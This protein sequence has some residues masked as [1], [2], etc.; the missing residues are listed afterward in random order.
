MGP[1]GLGFLT[2]KPITDRKRIVKLLLQ[3]PL[4]PK[5]LREQMAPVVLTSSML[6]Q[7]TTTPSLTQ[8]ELIDEIA[9]LHTVEMPT[10]TLLSPPICTIEG[11]RLPVPVSMA[12]PVLARQLAGA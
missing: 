4:T 1:N 2:I 12:A 9:P 8:V 5:W 6:A 7:A 3:S 11:L 10:T